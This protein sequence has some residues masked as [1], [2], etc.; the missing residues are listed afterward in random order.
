MADANS[1][2][3]AKLEHDGHQLADALPDLTIEANRIA[4]SVSHG[5][6]GRRRAGSGETFWQFRQFQDNDSF[7]QIDWRR[8]ASSDQ[9]YIREREWEAAHTVWLWPDLSSSMEFR[10]HLSA[11]PK[12]DR[13]VVL[14]LALAELLINGGERV[15]LMGRTTPTANRG[16]PTKLAQALI[17]EEQDNI[18][19]H[20]LP[21]A[22]TLPRFSGAV[23]ISDFL[24]PIETIKERLNYIAA[25]NVS[26]HMIQVLD[27]A[28]ETLPY[29]GRTEFLGPTGETRWVADRA[30]SLRE[31]YQKRLQ[32]HRDELR[33][34]AN[35]LQWSFT[36]HHTDQPASQPLLSL[37]MRMQAAASS[38]QM[39]GGVAA[40]GGQL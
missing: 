31:T 15:A 13:S 29:T 36:V 17:A 37:I 27:P 28:E 5:I 20:N 22:V 26:G 39:T 30:E 2:S 4:A 21:P 32:A 23:L 19:Q 1:K 40:A 33:D 18:A 12:R 3:I 16:A 35:R 34:F 24:E 7:S 6:H 38:Y 10:S 9:L 25:N 14:M 11:T 8:S